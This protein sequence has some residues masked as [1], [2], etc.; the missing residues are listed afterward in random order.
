MKSKKHGSLNFRSTTNTSYHKNVR[1]PRSSIINAVKIKFTWRNWEGALKQ[2]VRWRR[3]CNSIGNCFQLKNDEAER[4]NEPWSDC[5]QTQKMICW[6]AE[7][8]LEVPKLSQIS[9]HLKLRA[10]V[11]QGES[12]ERKKYVQRR[13]KARRR[14]WE[15]EKVREKGATHPRFCSYHVICGLWLFRSSNLQSSRMR[16]GTGKFIL[17]FAWVSRACDFTDL[18][19][20]GN[21]YWNSNINFM[22]K[23]Y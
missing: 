13:S 18:P 21:S 14:L 20:D 11:C 22:L 7:F 4:A 17:V 6:K 9:L 2:Q 23:Y 1:N 5:F 12:E 15:D 3:Y 8:N 10:Y 19:A 16:S